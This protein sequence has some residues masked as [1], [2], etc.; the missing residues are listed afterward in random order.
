[1]QCFQPGA[2]RTRCPQPLV[3][4]KGFARFDPDR[5]VWPWMRF[6]AAARFLP[7]K[8][9]GSHHC[10]APLLPAAQHC[11]DRGKKGNGERG[12][13]R[14][15]PM[16]LYTEKRPALL[17]TLTQATCANRLRQ[18]LSDQPPFQPPFQ[19]EQH[20]RNSTDSAALPPDEATG[21]RK[22][23]TGGSAQGLTA[24]GNTSIVSCSYPAAS[25]RVRLRLPFQ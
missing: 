14:S 18:H 22:V 1:M 7:G 12:C 5:R 15:A 20:G 17:E 2:R 6:P 3:G 24:E 21:W 16:P 23:G 4:Q 11:T 19:P 9:S 13:K 10:P 25:R 8:S